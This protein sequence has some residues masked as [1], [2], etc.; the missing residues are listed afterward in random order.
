M[1]IKEANVYDVEKVLKTR[2]R[3]GKI[4]YY[5]KW[6]GYPDK[7]NSWIN[8]LSLVSANVRSSVGLNSRKKR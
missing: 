7:F 1:I 5:E 4:E 3:N 2:R 6:K 8:S